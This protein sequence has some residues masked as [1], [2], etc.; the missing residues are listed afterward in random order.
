MSKP[1]IK[2][3][4]AGGGH[5]DT[6]EENCVMEHVQLQWLMNNGYMTA[7]ELLRHKTD[8]PSCTAGYICAVAQHINDTTSPEERQLLK[9]LVPRLLNEAPAVKDPSKARGVTKRVVSQLLRVAFEEGTEQERLYL[10]QLLATTPPA[11]PMRA[12]QDE[13][14]AYYARSGVELKLPSRD[15][16]EAYDERSKRMNALIALGAG[17]LSYA[18]C[19]VAESDPMYLDRLI[20][21]HQKA[22]AE[23]GLLGDEDAFV[24]PHDEIRAT[25][26]FLEQFEY[27]DEDEN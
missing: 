11:A 9:H 19:C 22:L 4:I 1:Q 18:L 6:L 13:I 26:L 10:E 14:M 21:L 2:D 15:V 25:D 24:D 20:D 5:P 12:T 27:E 23:E 7:D 8:T 3:R 16:E 17:D